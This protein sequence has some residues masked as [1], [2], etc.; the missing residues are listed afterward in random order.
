MI[1]RTKTTIHENGSKTTEPVIRPCY[2]NWIKYIRRQVSKDAYPRKEPLD[3]YLVSG[4]DS[5]EAM[6]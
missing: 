4:Y 1:T 6:N 5:I 2:A 3:C